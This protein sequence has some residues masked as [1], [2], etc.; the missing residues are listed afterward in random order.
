[1]PF[2]IRNITLSPDDREELLLTRILRHFSL[3]PSEVKQWRIVRKGVDARRKKQ[4]RVVYTVELTLDRE[5]AFARRCADNPDVERVTPAA[6]FIP[7]QIESSKKI[8]I[9]GFGPAGIFAAL[10]LSEYGLAPLV[11]ERG[12]EMARRVKDVQ[13]FWNQGSLD[14]ESNVQFGEGGAGTFSD[15]KLTTR[16][17]DSN[18]GYILDQLVRFGAPQEIRYLAKPHI[19]TD[20]LR[21]VVVNMRRHLA[22]RGIEVRFGNRLT[23]IAAEGGALRGALINE[24]LEE[25]CDVLVLAPG[26]SARDTYRML[27]DAGVRLEQKAF[28][29]GLRVEH[30]QELINTIQY[31]I[32]GHPHLPQAEY[33]LAYNDPSSGRSAYSFCMC[34]G[35]MV[36]AS[37]SE[38]GGVVTNG[39]SNHLRNAPFANSALVVTVGPRDF[40]DKSPLAGIEFQRIWERKAFTA[41]GEGYLAP[42]QNLLSFLGE[43]GDLPLRSSYLPGVLRYDLPMVLPPFVTDTLRDGLRQFDRKMRGFVTREATLTGVETRTSAPVRIERGEDMQSVSLAGLY[44]A[45]EGAGYAGGIVSAALDGI[46]VADA[47]AERLRMERNLT[48]QTSKGACFE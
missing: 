14:P 11:I 28:S 5:D 3:Q 6:S 22:A 39:M 31:G 17:R 40:T 2:L 37:S 27:H 41:A 20:R 12:A 43:K 44:P 42:A 30:P 47:V 15:G 29:I 18:I 36:V 34:P 25:A 9:V 33:A 38:T 35:G 32:P 16:V 19:G 10:R 4:I 46:R 1:M 45:G 13:L 21:D 8:V 48:L 24:R 26:H 7:V 23:G